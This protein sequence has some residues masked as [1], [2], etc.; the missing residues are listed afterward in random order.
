MRGFLI[1]TKWSNGY[2]CSKCGKLLPKDRYNMEKHSTICWKRP[3]READILKEHTDQV[4]TIEDQHQKVFLIVSSPH[5]ESLPDH[6]DSIAAVKWELLHKS[7]FYNG[8]NGSG[9][10][11]EEGKNSADT[12]IDRIRDGEILPGMEE[13]A[14]QIIHRVFPEVLAVYDLRMFAYICTH[15]GFRYRKVLP[16]KEEKALLKLQPGDHSSKTEIKGME[17]TMFSLQAKV[18]RYSTETYILRVTAQW[19]G[20]NTVFLF[21]RGYAACSDFSRVEGFLERGCRMTERSRKAAAFFDKIYPENLLSQY[22]KYSDNILVPLI[23]PDYHKGMELAAKSGTALLAENIRSLWPFDWGPSCYDNLRH[24][25]GLPTKVLRRLS[26]ECIT[27]EDIKR[28]EEVF[29]YNPEFLNFKAITPSMM[30]Y[31]QTVNVTHSDERPGIADKLTD[32]QQIRILRFLSK[33]PE[34]G[35]VYCDYLQICEVLEEYVFGL[36]PSIP[37]AQ[38]R[39]EALKKVK[40]LNDIELETRFR[41]RTE[42]PGYLK[43][44]TCMAEKEKGVFKDDDYVVIAPRQPRDLFVEGIKMHNC[45]SQYTNNVADG[46]TCIYFL[47]RKDKPDKSFG[48][49]EV[50]PDKYGNR[51]LSQA[52]AFANGRLPEPAQKYLA[53]W[54]RIKKIIP[55]ALDFWPAA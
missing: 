5:V 48:T 2:Y 7:C 54:C 24:L 11:F 46:Y 53:K 12:I 27:D 23:A 22:M 20:E 4:Y 17:D 37:L 45:V 36:T 33:H 15:K 43:L 51:R 52:K 35:P 44:T 30:E 50:R 42:S 16:E 10:C 39:D 41:T 25:F 18:Y 8:K 40:N 21:S 13:E 26:R 38:A 47:R 32:E 55:D 6:D 31:F 3:L 49:L 19:K 34:D 29:R 28:L 1:K 9:I 14:A